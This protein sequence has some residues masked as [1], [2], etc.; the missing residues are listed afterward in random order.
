ML[1]GFR[2]RNFGPLVD[3]AIGLDPAGVPRGSRSCAM[4]PVSALIGRNATGKTAVLDGLSFLSDCLRLG[5]PAASLE[6]DRGG[7]TRLRTH[8]ATDP[9]S[10]DVYLDAGDPDA[11]VGYRLELDCDAQGRPSVR[12]EKAWFLKTGQAFF[13][14]DQGTGHVLE[15]PGEAGENRRDAGVANLKHPA[16]SAYGRL[17][18][19]G[20]LRAIFDDISRWYFCRFDPRLAREPAHAGGQ[21]HVSSTGHNLGNVI[22]YLEDEDPESLR[23][24]LD[25]IADRIPEIGGLHSRKTH[26]GHLVLQVGDDSLDD[27]SVLRRLSDGTLKMFALLLLLSDP[28]PRPMICLEEPETGL[29]HEMLD[30]LA[31]E[32]RHHAAGI[33]RGRPGAQVLFTTHNP[34]LLD[35][36]RPDEVWVLERPGEGAPRARCIGADPVVQSL[37]SQGIGLGALWYSHHFEGM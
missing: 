19:H 16:L 15:R 14:L 13:R 35:S 3:V 33:R 10:F 18:E 22:Q 23:V 37:Y 31:M 32:I 1:L 28:S 20:R 29:H 12:S 6:G 11:P 27:P 36:L 4:T 25:R 21:H 24:I 30:T 5:V 9:V 34:F 2:I 8:D 17:K 7:Y 26:D